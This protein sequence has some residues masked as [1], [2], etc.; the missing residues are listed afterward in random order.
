[1]VDKKLCVGCHTCEL[2]CSAW[3]EN[4]FRPTL[5]RLRI[6]CVP[7][8]AVVTVRTCLQTACA[9]CRDIC[10][11]DA[12]VESTARVAQEDGGLAGPILVVDEG[13]CTGCGLCVDAC[14]TGVIGLH[15]DS[16]K[17]YKCD[18]CAGDPQCLRSCQN[19]MVRAVWVKV[20]KPD[21]RVASR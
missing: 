8:T 3:H 12:V 13:R 21:V 18:L 19:P 14:P 20:D 4:A 9:K 1:M 5:S 6:E 15:P 11:E 7:Q 16:N 10:P 2:A 17:A